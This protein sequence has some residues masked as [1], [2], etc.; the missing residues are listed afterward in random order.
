MAPVSFSDHSKKKRSDAMGE[1]LDTTRRLD[2]FF[3]Y[4][5]FVSCW[6]TWLPSAAAAAEY[7]VTLLVR[8][9]KKTTSVARQKKRA[10]GLEEEGRKNK[11]EKKQ[12]TFSEKGIGITKFNFGERGKR[13][14]RQKKKSWTVRVPSNQPPPSFLQKGKKSWTRHK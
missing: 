4:F 2:L 13:E 7:D 3:F 10:H 5:F 8:R 6:K 1:L 9:G 14:A 12:K 11:Q